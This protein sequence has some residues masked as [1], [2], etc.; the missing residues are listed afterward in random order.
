MLV[1]GVLSVLLIVYV[2]GGCACEV[3]DYRGGA[4]NVVVDVWMVWL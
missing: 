1:N 3:W 4:A 2:D